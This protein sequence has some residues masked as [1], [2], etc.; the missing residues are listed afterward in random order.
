MKA[1][2]LEEVKKIAVKD[3]PRPELEPEEIL[4][5]IAACGICGTDIKLYEG[6]Y[7]AKTPVVL[8]HEYAGKVVEI[9]KEVKNIKI[10]DRIVPDPNESCGACNW[11][12]SARPCFCNDLAAYGVLK[13]GGFAEY[14]KLGEKGAYKIP[15]SLDYESASFTEPVS[16]A[17]HGVDRINYKPGD[18]VLIIGGGA[19][20]QIH[21]QL[22][23]NSG[24]NQLIL[25]EV[26]EDRIDMA[27]KFGAAHVINPKK[28]ELKKAVL[29]LTDGSGPDVV[30]EVVGH[31]STISQAID[32]AGKTA[33]VL[34]FGFAPEGEK[35]SFIPFDVLSKE[36]TIMGS[37]VNPYTFPRALDIL[38]S[39]KVDVKPLISMRIPLDKIMDGFNAM[40]EKP[41]GF[42]K[43]L[44][45]F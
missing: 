44:V 9:G 8:G 37:W 35:A 24:V 36:L 2:V 28:T 39:K 31:T 21:L 42:M 18:N 26:E 45:T 1:A 14:A 32:V 7:T 11:C 15:D 4:V 6:K 3:I 13:D 5:K 41:K 30:V 19:M 43:A 16:C 10:G 20:G 38:A 34:I 40:Q 33:K 22:A 27:K 12:R 29:D 23:L 17:V 25:A